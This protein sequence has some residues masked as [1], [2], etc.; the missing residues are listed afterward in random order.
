MQAISLRMR[1]LDVAINFLPENH[2]YKAHLEFRRK[3]ACR[4]ISVISFESMSR[5]LQETV[6]SNHFANHLRYESLETRD[7]NVDGK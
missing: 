7:S 3:I 4:N 5:T 1:L 2:W 6:E